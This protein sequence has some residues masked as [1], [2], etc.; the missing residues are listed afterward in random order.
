MNKPNSFARTSNGKD[1]TVQN[2]IEDQLWR[3]YRASGTAKNREA[4]I[5]HY[6]WYVK[7][8][9]NRL[10]LELP[11]HIKADDLVSSGIIGLID[12][13]EKFDDSRK[14]LFRTYA[15]S[16][17]RGAIIDELRR[18]DWAPRAVRRKAREIERSAQAL[19]Q[20]LN[21][22]PTVNEIAA[23]CKLSVEEVTKTFR[24]VNATALLSLEDILWNTDDQKGM[25]RIDT[26]E[27]KQAANPK[28]MML[29]KENKAML[30]TQIERLDE[31]ERLVLTLYYYEEMNLKEIGHILHVSESRVSQLHAE[32]IE[33]VRRSI[34]K[35]RSVA[36]ESFME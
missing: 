10:A 14:N 24:D 9:C 16:R 25:S 35:S 30:A 28:R 13:I 18:L 15:F 33:H 2:G 32:A 26:I 11:S 6:L 5:L 34:M 23:S 27:D 4:L 1:Y 22:Q 3:N 12:A 31:K 17:I 36:V 8:I 19:K 21:R 20:K 29:D 7:Y